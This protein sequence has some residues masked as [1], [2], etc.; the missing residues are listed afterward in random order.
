[1]RSEQVFEG[2]IHLLC[3][4]EGGTKAWQHTGAQLFGES[5]VRLSEGNKACQGKK[6]CTF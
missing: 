4:E 2:Q 6:R 5:G 3:V 1:M